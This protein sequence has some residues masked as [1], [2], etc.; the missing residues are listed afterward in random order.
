MSRRATKD[1][2]AVQNEMREK[3]WVVQDLQASLDWVKDWVGKAEQ[4]VSQKSGRALIPQWM[5]APVDNTLYEIYTHPCYLCNKSATL[6]VDF[7][8]FACD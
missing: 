3:D 4:I 5:P 6:Y 2:D 8:F 1:K 7:S